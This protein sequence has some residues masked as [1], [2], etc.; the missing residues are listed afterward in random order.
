[1]RIVAGKHGAEVGLFTDGERPDTC[2]Y[3]I[4]YTPLIATYLKEKWPKMAENMQKNSC[5]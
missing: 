1:M 3:Y 2:T 5:I 4:L